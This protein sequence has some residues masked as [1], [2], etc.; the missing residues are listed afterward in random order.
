MARRR[1]HI[2]SDFGA[3]WNSKLYPF[4]GG[5]SYGYGNGTVSGNFLTVWL[6]S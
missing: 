6:Y 1:S 2:Y 4:H 5:V 3:N